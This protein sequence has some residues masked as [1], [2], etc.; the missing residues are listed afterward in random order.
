MNYYPHHIGD[1]LRDTAHLTIVEH[2]A[3]RRMLDLYYASE[4][5]LPLDLEWLCRLIRAEETQERDAVHFVLTHYFSKKADG[6]HNKR[7][8]EEIAKNKPRAKAARINGKLG[9]RPKT[10][11]VISENPVGTQMV[12]EKVKSGNPDESSQ[13]Q[14]QNQINTSAE[15]EKIWACFPS[16]VGSNSKAKALK[17]FRARLD[18][19]CSAEEMLAG[20]KRYAAFIRATGK[21][22]TQYVKMAASF[23]GP[24][25]EFREPWEIP[26]AKISPLYSREGVM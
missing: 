26:S 10:Q 21:E 9:G 20:V 2:G 25:K 7:A 1:Y 24:D 15:F 19:G 18:E 6:W 4:K 16:R 8:D 22:N 12:S 14:N 23:L 11:R 3:Y 13:N 5:A 17:A